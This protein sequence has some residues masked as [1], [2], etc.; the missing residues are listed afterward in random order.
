MQGMFVVV[1][2]YL[3]WGALCRQQIQSSTQF[4]GWWPVNSVCS[5]SMAACWVFWYSRQAM[6]RQPIS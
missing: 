6:S 5:M 1:V 4:Q 2:E 3:H